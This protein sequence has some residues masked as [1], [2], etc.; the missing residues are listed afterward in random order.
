MYILHTYICRYV[1]IYQLPPARYNPSPTVYEPLKNN[2][3]ISTRTKFKTFYI[4]KFVIAP[5]KGFR[6]VEEM[7]ECSTEFSKQ[8]FLNTSLLVVHFSYTVL[9]QKKKTKKKNQRSK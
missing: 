2:P 4:R 9:F 5:V 1:Y 8:I 7:Q 3:Q 6:L